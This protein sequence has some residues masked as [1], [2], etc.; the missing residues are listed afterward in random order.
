MKHANMSVE[1]V[2]VSRTVDAPL[3]VNSGRRRGHQT[4]EGHQEGSCQSSSPGPGP[5]ARAA[6]PRPP[7]APAPAPR[8]ATVHL[9]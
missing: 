7:P 4:V 8:H 5:A 6:A 1:T 3:A 2:C 9:P